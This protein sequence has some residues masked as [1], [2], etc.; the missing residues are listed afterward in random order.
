M[1]EIEWETTPKRPS[2]RRAV[3]H[4]TQNLDRPCR[5]IAENF[6]AA[7]SRMDLFCVG[8]EGELV[9]LR[10][11]DVGDDAGGLTRSLSDLVWLH[12]R[13]KDL[14]KL[15][16]D[17]GIQPSAEARAILLC[18][19]FRPETQAA[20]EFLPAGSVTLI[21]YRCYRHRGQLSVLLE[22][23]ASEVHSRAHPHTDGRGGTADPAT[24][25]LEAPQ[26]TL[27]KS[28]DQTSALGT[29]QSEPESAGSFRTGLCDGDL[30][31]D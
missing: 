20:I 25:V 28:S 6:L 22:G 2:L 4:Q 26:S 10:I 12:A 29:V 11:T 17:L 31:A 3:R 19:D 18:P 15:M 21:R 27:R 7:D 9:S 23:A 14:G 8:N 30:R 24:S 1:A 13:T 5:V 16:P